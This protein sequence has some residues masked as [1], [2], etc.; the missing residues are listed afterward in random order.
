VQ[1]VSLRGQYVSLSAEITAII[2]DPIT[3]DA[4][5]DVGPRRWPILDGSKDFEHDVSLAD[6]VPVKCKDCLDARGPTPVLALLLGCPGRDD[7]TGLT[8]LNSARIV[9]C[10]ENVGPGRARHQ[11]HREAAADDKAPVS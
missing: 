4:E 7:K 9:R 6:P 10:A 5:N 2:V 8:E 11:Q 1:R 3:V